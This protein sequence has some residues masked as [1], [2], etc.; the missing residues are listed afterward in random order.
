MRTWMM[1][2]GLAVILAVGGGL[3]ADD[4]KKGTSDKPGS[5]DKVRTDDRRSDDK[6]RSDD[7]RT[8][9]R[10]GDDR[11]SDD[12]RSDEKQFNDSSFVD[13]AYTAGQNEVIMGR[14]ALQRSQNEDVRRFAQRMIDDHGK[15]NQDLILIVSELRI[16]VPDKP[17]PDQEKDLRR[18]HSQEVRDFD[19]E[20]MDHMVSDH[21][22]AV[23]LFE[24]GSK[25]LKNERLKEFAT[26]TL[27]TLKEH[28]KMAKDVQA[29]VSGGAGRERTGTAERTD[30]GVRT[31]PAERTGTRE[32]G[33]GLTDNEFVTTAANSGMA[34]VAIGKLAQEKA[35]NAD[36][37]KLAERVV[38]DHTK[39]NEELMRIA[40]DAGINVPDKT[41]A[42]HESKVKHFG[43]E[44]DKNFDKEFVNHMVEGHTKSVDLFTR[45]S[46]ELKNDQLRTFASN[47]L[48][49]IKEHLDMA[50][51]LQGQLGRGE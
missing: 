8:D 13:H 12:K 1:V 42:D 37:K 9:D 6:V 11:R 40:K 15:A 39:A 51:K 7:R 22:K 27:P 14:L 3:R 28:Q 49:T 50:K 19:K 5:D 41:D 30:T 26:R 32:A 48:P 10:R 47:T 36:V 2:F 18:F 45:A 29:K 24:Q 17:L 46:K 31:V 25:E 34:E 33:K 23:K 35:K 4:D 21:E 44:A 43:S 16:A 38:T 20:F